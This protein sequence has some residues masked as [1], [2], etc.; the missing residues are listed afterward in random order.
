MTPAAYAPAGAVSLLWVTATAD[1]T[2][3]NDSAD[4]EVVVE[5]QRSVDS[6]TERTL[7]RA[8]VEAMPAR[9]ADDLLRA[10]PGLHQSAHGG[11]GKAYQYFL[12]GF[13]AVH[14]A[15]LAIDIDGVP[16]NEVSNVHAHGYLDLHFL[17]PLLVTQVALR[18][19]SATVEG[20]DFAVAGSASFQLGLERPG[21]LVSAGGGTDRSGEVGLAYRPRDSSPGT[22]VAADADIGQGIGMARSWRQLRAGAGI[23]GDL[24]QTRARAW[25]LAY[26]GVFDSPGALRED[27]VLTGEMDFYDAYPGSGG[28]HSTRVLASAQLRQGSDHNAWQATLWGG[29]RTLSL[30]QNF[31]GWYNNE[32]QGDGTLQHYTATSGGGVGRGWWTLRPSL[33]LLA[34]TTFRIDQIEQAVE[35]VTAT[36]L[37]WSDL[38]SLAATQSS[39]GAWSSLEIQPNARWNIE[40]GIRAEAFIVDVIGRETAW[41][42]VLAPRLQT[43]VRMGNTVT[44][45]LSGGRGYR[46]PD[47][48]GA[49]DGGRA[50]L[51][52][53]D[54]A[55][56]GATIAPSTWWSWRGAVFGTHVS[57]EIVFDHV[58][59]RYLATGE[60]RRLGVDTG[61]Q[62]RFWDALRC[63]LDLTLSDGQY[64]STG[65]GIPYAP[66][67]LGVAGLFAERIMLGTTE[68]TG[69]VRAWYLGPR[70][71]PG[72]F[73]STP[74]GVIDAT[75]TLRWDRWGASVEVDNLLGSQWTD[76]QF[77]Y[78]SRWDRDAPRS[79]LPVRH[80][81][82]GTPRAA[83]F[84]VSRSF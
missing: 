59:A 27:D 52:I 82:A 39:L 83:R 84:S 2:G 43:R 13:D 32:T 7:D 71:L 73:M 35:A 21:G 51:A 26:D 55:E 34:G 22:F 31:T 36:G 68:L 75:S 81:T 1:T 18:P 28:G 80:F 44:G 9:S 45:F 37:P 58:S 23:E 33:H 74:S 14:G 62:L 61:F 72:G 38:S 47:A 5:A 12:R 46:S 64:T 67:L 15:D 65:E 76:G 10:M 16:V 41:A 40:P 4:S 11:H 48:R 54:S 78:P 56:L 30:Q 70:P 63:D 60:T 29:W 79:E 50:P 69:G 8:A 66:R 25:L 6:A 49:G 24:G 17:P 20:G 53:S 77:L 57:D 19:G 3:E 42:P